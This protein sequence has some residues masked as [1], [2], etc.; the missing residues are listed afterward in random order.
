MTTYVALVA[1]LALPSREQTS[2]F[3]DHVTDA[4]RRDDLPALGSG[5]RLVV[6]LDP[7]AGA[8]SDAPSWRERFGHW[9]HAVVGAE[10]P[11]VVDDEG[12]LV[13]VPGRVTVRGACA[14]DALREGGRDHRRSVIHDTLTASR[15]MFA[16][17]R[18]IE[19]AVALLE[20]IGQAT[21]L[22]EIA[23]DARTLRRIHTARTAQEVHDAF[24]ELTRYAGGMIP[25]F[26]DRVRCGLDGAI[27]RYT[28]A[29]LGAEGRVDAP[30]GVDLLGAFPASVFDLRDEM[31]RDFVRGYEAGRQWVEERREALRQALGEAAVSLERA[32][33]PPLAPI[34]QDALAKLDVALTALP[35]RSTAFDDLTDTRTTR[36]SPSRRRLRERPA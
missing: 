2:L 10:S 13:M 9:N 20:A 19:A 15:A 23:R 14:L 7:N 21:P 33:P 36:F 22:G 28:L 25:G 34:D 8:S 6:F 35:P 17:W 4:L 18:A 29:S 16:E 1:P 31:H 3:A 30:D 26:G 24:R 27:A 11:H 32:P 12:G 5:R